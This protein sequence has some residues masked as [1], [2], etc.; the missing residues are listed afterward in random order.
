VDPA[1]IPVLSASAAP[2]AIAGEELDATAEN[3]LGDLRG[4]DARL[5]IDGSNCGSDDG[6][7]LELGQAARKAH[8]IVGD[9]AHTGKRLDTGRERV[10]RGVFRR[11][12]EENDGAVTL[13]AVNLVN[14][15]ALVEAEL[16]TDGFDRPRHLRSYRIGEGRGFS[17]RWR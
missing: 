13:D 8:D 2:Y 3:D 14:A 4:R 11:M 1:D 12:T 5:L 9:G 15:G 17:R 10:D 16:G 6:V 7:L